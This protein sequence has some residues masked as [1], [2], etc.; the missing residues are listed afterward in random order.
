MTENTQTKIYNFLRWSEKYTKTDM[1]YLAEG[2]FWLTIAQIISSAAAFLLAVF[3][4]NFLPKEVYGTYR[5]VLSMA[6]ILA[7]FSLPG[8]N[9]SLVQAVARGF[10]G[11]F[12]PALK[13]RIRWGI[14]AGLSS[15]ALAG[16]YFLNNNSTLTFSF[17]IAAVFLPLMDPFGIY[18]SLL[19]GRKN[20]KILTKYGVASQIIAC[21]SLISVLFFT[22]NLYLIIF[23]YF[24]SWTLSRYI[25]LRLVLNKFKPNEN[26]DPSTIGYGKHLSL[27]TV[28][29]TI[30]D[31]FDNLIIFHFLG[32]AGVAIYSFAVAPPEQ[33]K[34]LLKNINILALPK[35]SQKPKEEIQKTIFSKSMR[36][37]AVIAIIVA[38]YIFAAPFLFHI[39][40]PTYQQS[41]VYSQ[42]FS[43]SLIAVVLLIPY[44]AL[45]S[46]TAKKELYLYNTLT[47]AL[48]IG[49]L[50]VLVYYF[51]ILGAILSRM[52]MRFAGLGFSFWL[53]KKI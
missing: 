19:S 44:T 48:Q 17:L 53:L 37:A 40:F 12:L 28:I 1:V 42:L 50:I 25:F 6:G 31:Y 3:F 27:M 46:Q 13:T 29:T 26:Q 14:M 43:V 20:F 24:A 33:I 18:E 8:I 10:E 9:A 41:V 49:L 32:A 15:L 34:S 30:A 39:F 4:A 36:L 2:G 16:Y 21:L 23:A 52:I 51:G 22:K 5:Y 35:F 45:Q 47:S 11:S 7:I 38:I